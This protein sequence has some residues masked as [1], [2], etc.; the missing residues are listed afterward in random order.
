MT[1]AERMPASSGHPIAE[2]SPL[3]PLFEAAHAR[4]RVRAAIAPVTDEVDSLWPAERPF[5][6]RAVAGRRREFASGRRLARRL[7]RE[8]A[9]PECAILRD[10]DRVPVWPAAVVG[11]I[12]HSAERVVVALARAESAYGLGIDVEPDEAVKEGIERIVCTGEERAWLDRSA[13]GESPLERARRVKLFFSAKE[14]VYKA[15]YPRTRV[16]WGFHDV[17]LEL[18]E[19]AGR[20]LARLPASAGQPE[21]EGRFVRLPGTLV[22]AFVI[23]PR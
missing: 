16:F 12:S 6:E 13:P 2:R 15:F 14:A 21:A 22:S 9:L 7:L 3:E 19:P 10:D 5:I 4:G 18:D 17:T 1:G 11:S 20:L 23:P 8:L